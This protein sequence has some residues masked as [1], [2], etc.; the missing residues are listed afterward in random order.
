MPARGEKKMKSLSRKI[1]RTSQMWDVD[2]NSWQYVRHSESRRKLRRAIRKQ[3][4]KKLTKEMLD[5]EQN[6]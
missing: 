3:M 5:R 2:K 4:R 6:L 1:D